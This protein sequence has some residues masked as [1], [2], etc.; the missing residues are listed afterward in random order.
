[1]SKKLP[2][3]Y[4]EA[5]A[6]LRAKRAKLPIPPPPPEK[7]PPIY[8]ILN[9]K[10]APGKTSYFV[11]LC[12]PDSTSNRALRVPTHFVRIHECGEPMKHCRHIFELYDIPE[13]AEKVSDIIGS[14]FDPIRPKLSLYTLPFVFHIQAQ[15]EQE[16]RRIIRTQ[17]ETLD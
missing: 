7:L 10:L 4:A 13:D 3:T 9:F 6:A 15:A 16:T 17:L 2:I 8:S 11:P 1:M 12:N 14:E 5:L